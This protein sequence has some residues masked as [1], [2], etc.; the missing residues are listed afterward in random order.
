MDISG[1]VGGAAPAQTGAISEAEKARQARLEAAKTEADTTASGTKKSRLDIMSQYDMRNI[2]PREVDQI[3]AE[4]RENGHIDSDYMML[5]TY[6]EEFR[7]GLAQ[8]ISEATGQ[9][10]PFGEAE[11]TK[12]FDMISTVEYQKKLAK[13]FGDPTEAYDTM[14][15][16]LES[17]QDYRASR[18]QTAPQFAHDTTAAMLAAQEKAAAA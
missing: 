1:I 6:G 17:S 4:L 7:R 2:S 13:S 14:L 10:I 5:L 9:N 12:K 3:A 8:S 16:Y 18:A 11:A 15:A